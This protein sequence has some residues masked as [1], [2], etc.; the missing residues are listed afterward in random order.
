ML[1]TVS[2]RAWKKSFQ[3]IL[4]LRKQ[5]WEKSAGGIHKATVFCQKQL[6]G[7]DGIAKVRFPEQRSPTFLVP[8]T[9]FV[10]DSFSRDQG[11]GGLVSA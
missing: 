1:A 6:S 10:E 11:G 4:N 3:S 2:Y 8:E 5:V 7:Q 9:G